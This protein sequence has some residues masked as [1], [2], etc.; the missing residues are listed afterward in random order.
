MSFYRCIWCEKKFY[1]SKIHSIEECEGQK[2]WNDWL[3]ILDENRIEIIQEIKMNEEQ[4]KE[5]VSIFGE[6]NVFLM[7]DEMIISPVK[8]SMKKEQKNRRRKK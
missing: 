1:Q 3:E 4:L 7:D 6:G 5:I 8:V 2:E